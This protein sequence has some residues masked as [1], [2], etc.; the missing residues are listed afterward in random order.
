MCHVQLLWPMS[1]LLL[2]LIAVM[3]SLFSEEMDSHWK[4]ILLLEIVIFEPQ[5]KNFRASGG[6]AQAAEAMGHPPYFHLSLIH[7]SEPTRP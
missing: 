2:T 4:L 5:T 7:I 1:L 6:A 3:I